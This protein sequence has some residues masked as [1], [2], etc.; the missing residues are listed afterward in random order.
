MNEFKL[1]RKDSLIITTIDIIDDLGIQGL[2]TREIAK[3]EGISEATLFRH[4]KNKNDLLIAVLDY[5]ARFDE[6]LSQSVML[7]KLDSY[8]SVQYII[9]TTVE[10]YENYPAITSL[11]QLFDVLRYDEHLT[12]KV[13]KI[14]NNRLFYI[15]KIIDDAKVNN[16]L[17]ED[18]NT[19]D[20]VDLIFGIV[21]E[22]CLKWR[23]NDR[24]FSLTEKTMSTLDLI[25]RAYFKK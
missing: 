11:T 18:I 15:K 17:S 24:S 5:Y 9:R 13:N 4:Y 22:T 1:H 20:L 23:M 19:D 8:S 3:R 25:L 21:L 14:L 6:D 12:N 10:Y 7:K 16:E 2:S